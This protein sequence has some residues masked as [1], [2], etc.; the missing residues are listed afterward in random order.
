MIAYPKC[1][2]VEISTHDLAIN[3]CK[4]RADMYTDRGILELGFASSNVFKLIVQVAFM[5]FDIVR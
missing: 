5:K 4:V 1:R 3:Q 2:L